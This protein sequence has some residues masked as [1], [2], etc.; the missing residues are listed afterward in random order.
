MYKNNLRIRGEFL[1][2]LILLFTTQ[3][4]YAVKISQDLSIGKIVANLQPVWEALIEATKIVADCG[5][6]FLIGSGLKKYVTASRPGSGS[7]ATNATLTFLAGLFLV[8]TPYM[9]R[10]AVASLDGSFGSSTYAGNHQ[11]DLFTSTSLGSLMNNEGLAVFKSIITLLKLVGFIAVVKGFFLL[12]M[13]AA[14]GGQ[15]VSMAK[16]IWHWVGGI[17]LIIIVDIAK[18][19]GNQTGITFT[20]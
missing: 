1:F 19:L 12:R 11:Y 18:A 14:P 6:L 4:A 10:I 3:E 8:Y 16:I 13:I 20:L 2:L 5:G 17:G 9:I 7:N 15:N